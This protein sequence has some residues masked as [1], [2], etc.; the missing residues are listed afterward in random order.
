MQRF[1]LPATESAEFLARAE[2]RLREEY[3]ARPGF[4]LRQG[5]FW[6]REHWRQAQ[7]NLFLGARA[8]LEL[9]YE[10]RPGADEGTLTIRARNRLEFQALAGAALAGAALALL[11]FVLLVV[12]GLCGDTFVVAYPVRAFGGPHLSGGA[13]VLYALLPALAAGLLAFLALWPLRWVA[14][15]AG[16]SANRAARLPSPAELARELRVGRA[17]RGVAA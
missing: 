4:E 12:D 11:V 10:Q 6:P 14:R 2:Q 8:G 13:I 16:V 5:L 15:L 1:L 7:L 9:A 17:E 3:G